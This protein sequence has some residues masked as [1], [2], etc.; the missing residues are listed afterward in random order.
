MY[1]KRPSQVS[2]RATKGNVGNRKNSKTQI[3]QIKRRVVIFNILNHTPVTLRTS[4]C[5]AI[6][7]HFVAL[8][9]SFYI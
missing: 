9:V 7:K 4:L 5:N 8:A 2:N 3:S 1:Q 6:K